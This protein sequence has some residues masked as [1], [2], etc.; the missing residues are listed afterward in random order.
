MTDE[1]RQAIELAAK[2]W[3]GKIAAA[4]LVSTHKINGQTFARIRYGSE[5]PDVWTGP[6]RDAPCHDCAVS[7]G[8]YH[9]FNCDVER[10]AS[11]GGQLITCPCLHE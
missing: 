3:A 10:C 6:N 8:Q 4:Q 9:V 2:E 11:C 5:V 1:T 7:V